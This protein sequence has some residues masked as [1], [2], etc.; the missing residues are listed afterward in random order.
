MRDSTPRTLA[1]SISQV[2]FSRRSDTSTI[3]ALHRFNKQ[4][5][6]SLQQASEL[7]TGNTLPKDMHQLMFRNHV[8]STARLRR[9]TCF[10]SRIVRM[11]NENSANCPS[12]IGILTYQGTLMSASDNV[13]MCPSGATSRR[14]TRFRARE[15]RPRLK[16]RRNRKH[17]G[18]CH[19]P[20]IGEL[21]GSV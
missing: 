3:T 4:L 19:R 5:T 9:S 6:T 1:W 12:K 17:G 13:Y 15:S 11:R 2:T 20:M 21:T 16:G 14:A 10:S 8:R 7:A 18:A